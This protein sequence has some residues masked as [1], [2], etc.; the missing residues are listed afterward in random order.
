MASLSGVRK[1]IPP[2][3]LMWTKSLCY[4]RGNLT[5][6][7]K[8]YA[9][10]FA[11]PANTPGLKMIVSPFGTSSSSDFHNPVS[12]HHRMIES[13]TIF[14]DVFVPK[15]RVFMSGEWDFAGRVSYYLRPIPPVYCCLL[16]ASAV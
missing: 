4:Q 9:V 2:V 8:D 5:E 11:V 14:D 7:D 13:L 15:E 3:L 16:Q 1:R 6:P 10:A 12:A